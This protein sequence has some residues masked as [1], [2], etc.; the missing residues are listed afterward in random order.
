MKATSNGSAPNFVGSFGWS[1][2]TTS[3]IIIATNNGAAQG[4]KTSSFRTEAY[5]LLSLYLFLYHV[6]TFTA[7]PI[8]PT[9]SIYSDSKSVIDKVKDMVTWREYYS[10]KTLTADWDVLQALATLI[11]K[12]PDSMELHHIL[13]H[14]DNKKKYED[15]TL[16]AQL[17]VDADKLT[18]SFIYPN[19]ITHTK[20]SII[21]GS[22]VLLHSPEGTINSKYKKTL[23]QMIQN[24]AIIIHIQDK[25][26][27]NT[28]QF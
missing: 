1:A 19:N 8:P 25:N 6:F 4:F 9:T 11:R 27:W 7:F 2:K 22:I 10:T 28:N 3:G 23:R 24:K 14:Q 17:N 21:E 12:M 13:G 16:P 20:T 15:L 5:G 26:N 18:G